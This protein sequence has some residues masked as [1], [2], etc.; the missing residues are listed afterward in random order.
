MTK[1][2]TAVCFIWLLSGCGILS[3]ILY[4]GANAAYDTAL[5]NKTSDYK[6]S[7]K[8]EN[9]KTTEDERQWSEVQQE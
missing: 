2:I 4:T 8:K 1:L 3:E 9:Q 5:I 6:A 7:G